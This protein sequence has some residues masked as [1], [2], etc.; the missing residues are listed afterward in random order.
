MRP[1][2]ERRERSDAQRGLTLHAAAVATL[3]SIVI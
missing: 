3:C 2:Q 1:L